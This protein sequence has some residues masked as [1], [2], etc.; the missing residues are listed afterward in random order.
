MGIPKYFRWITNKHSNLII[1]VNNSSSLLEEDDEAL[2]D[3]KSIDNLFL[4]ANGLIHPCVRKVLSENKHLLKEHFDN[5]KNNTNE[6]KTK[7]TI[8]SK[9]EKKMFKS[10]VDYIIYLLEF[11]KPNKLLYIAIDGVAPR[12]K[13]NKK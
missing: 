13:M 6:I 5:Y 7:L 2:K 11:S 9:L 8:Y 3:C 1:D 12:A 10:I 4:D